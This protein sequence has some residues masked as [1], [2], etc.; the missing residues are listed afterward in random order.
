MFLFSNYFKAINQKVRELSFIMILAIPTF[1]SCN[2]SKGFG[3]PIRFAFNEEVLF[4][5]DISVTYVDDYYKDYLA[6]GELVGLMKFKFKKNNDSTVITLSTEYIGREIHIDIDNHNNSFLIKHKY[7]FL[8]QESSLH[9]S[10]TVLISPVPYKM[11]VKRKFEETIDLLKDQKVIFNDSL[12]VELHEPEIVENANEE[13]VS[14]SRITF[15]NSDDSQQIT[16]FIPDCPYAIDHLNV[17]D[18]DCCWLNMLKEYEAQT[19]Y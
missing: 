15:S 18:A 19:Q 14:F 8:L 4:D 16:N 7:S 10:V 3:E 5:D 1:T 6:S 2:A 13:T 11:P 17:M 12:V 9:Q